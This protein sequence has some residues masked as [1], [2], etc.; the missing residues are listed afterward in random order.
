[1]TDADAE[2]KNSIFVIF[3]SSLLDSKQTQTNFCKLF[4][5][6]FRFMIAFEVEVKYIVCDVSMQSG[7][8]QP[9]MSTF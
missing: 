5:F 3:S 7:C 1:M 4:F 8:H 6:L 9:P 2:Q